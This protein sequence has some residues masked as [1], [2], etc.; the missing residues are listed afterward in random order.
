MRVKIKK[1]ACNELFEEKQK[2]IN[3][4]K[5]AINDVISGKTEEKT[6]NNVRNDLEQ[7]GGTNDIAFLK[8]K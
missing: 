6:V 8:D 2:T 7:Y 5:S 3:N 4:I 1:D